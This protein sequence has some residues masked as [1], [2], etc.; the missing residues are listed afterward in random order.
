MADEIETVHK[1]YVSLRV[2]SIAVIDS[3]IFLIKF[4]R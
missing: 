1:E 2:D 4:A 3:L